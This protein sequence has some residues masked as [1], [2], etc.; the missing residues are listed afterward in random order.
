MCFPC[1]F[2]ALGGNSG[3]EHYERGI[4]PADQGYLTYWMTEQATVFTL[5]YG[6]AKNNCVSDRSMMIK[7]DKIIALCIWID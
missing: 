7:W 6:K 2:V 5:I 3:D 1:C 4:S